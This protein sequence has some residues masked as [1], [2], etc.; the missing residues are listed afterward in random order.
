MATTAR[1]LRATPLDATAALVQDA[2]NRSHLAA[3]CIRG[4]ETIMT[5][6]AGEKAAEVFRQHGGTLRIGQGPTLGVSRSTVYRMAE[7]GQVERL[8]RGL[9]RLADMPLLGDPDLVVVTQM[10]PGSVVCLV[11]ALA[12]HDLTTQIPHEIQIAVSRTSRYPK[13]SHPPVRVFRY[14]EEMLKAGVESHDVDGH[15]IRVFSAEKTIADGFKYRNKIGLDIAIEALRL[16]WQ[17]RRPD[18]PTIMR[19]AHL[20]R[21]DRIIRPYVQIL[22]FE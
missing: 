9:Y 14:Q 20:C 17:R 6:S 22:A 2:A 12:H 5:T 7:A 1:R 16:Y 13:M 8:A 19:Y 3:F 11:S 15:T 18:V 21:V 4:G 10:V